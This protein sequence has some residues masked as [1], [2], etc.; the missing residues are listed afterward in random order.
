MH[1]IHTMMGVRVCVCVCVC[2]GGGGGGGGVGGL[3][4]TAIDRENCWYE[5]HK[6]LPGEGFHQVI[7]S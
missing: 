3:V 4:V 6:L 7:I 2:G 5:T 1:I